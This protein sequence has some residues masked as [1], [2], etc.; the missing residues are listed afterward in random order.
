MITHLVNFNIFSRDDTSFENPSLPLSHPPTDRI[1]LRRW[2]NFLRR[3]ILWYLQ[4]PDKNNNSNIT[5]R[6]FWNHTFFISFIYVWN[7]NAV[8]CIWSWYDY[9]IKWRHT[10][11]W[12][13]SDRGPLASFLFRR[14]RRRRRRCGYIGRGRCLP[15][16]VHAHRHVLSQN[17][18]IHRTSESAV[19]Q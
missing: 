8:S 9:V 15:A 1:M 7:L 2:F 18:C 19:L 16:G 17:H 14:P 4:K 5:R 6:I 10:N 12:P 13:R 11:N 3:I